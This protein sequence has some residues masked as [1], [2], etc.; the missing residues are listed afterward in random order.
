[1]ESYIIFGEPNSVKT[2]FEHR[3]IFRDKIRYN[4]YSGLE[5]VIREVLDKN[6]IGE[7][8]FY[9]TINMISKMEANS[10]IKEMISL[11][12]YFE[13]RNARKIRHFCFPVNRIQPKYLNNGQFKMALRKT[14]MQ[15][16]GNYPMIIALHKNRRVPHIHIAIGTMNSDGERL[17]IDKERLER[18]RY[19]FDE[20]LVFF[21]DSKRE[22]IEMLA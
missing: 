5:F 20:N 14:L 3:L 17:R 18:F 2:D 21:Y 1:M 13:V 7:N 11:F 15:T 4:D 8:G 22:F 9:E 6:S 19:F 16:F 12:Q 10:I